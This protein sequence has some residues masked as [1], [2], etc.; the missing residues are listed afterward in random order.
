MQENI[1][2]REESLKQIKETAQ[3]G[4]GITERILNV[5]P[6]GVCITD[7]EGIF[8]YV[9]PRYREIYQYEREELIGQH[10]TIMVPEKLKQRMI[11]LHKQFIE[12]KHEMHGEW[13]VQRKDGKKIS[14]LVS[15]AYL[16]D[17]L[18]GAP[19][20]MTF[21]VDTASLSLST[22]NLDATVEMLNRKLEAQELAFHISSHDMRN[23]IGNISQL[24]DLLRATSLDDK[25]NK[26][27]DIIH[28]LSLRTLDMLKMSADYMKMEKGNYQP[29]ISSFNLL[30]ALSNEI[31]AYSNE[32][33]NR[34]ITFQTCLN[35]EEANFDKQELIVEADKAYMERMLGNLIGNAVEA[36]PDGEQVKLEVDTKDKLK[37]TIHNKG[38][39]PQE[40]RNSFFDKFS[41][42]GKE[43][44]TGLGT[45]IARLVT[46]LHN[47]DISFS[48]S[49][50]EGT[51]LFV[52]LPKEILQDSD[53]K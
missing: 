4:G 36:S 46:E 39:V 43:E 40:M 50:E 53:K 33:E 15:A 48:T 20:K 6:I 45:Y 12:Q 2:T 51:A 47:G 9:N 22:D 7:K 24:A 52:E 41:T 32:S 49:N 16:E 19:Q 26:Y 1:N 29:D 37:V 35:G 5:L 25:Q 11:H 13:E 27:V 3:E 31:G 8:T 14:I 23:N 34:K 21:V 42:A 10:F 18:N 38:E 17:E 30:K 44:G 28:Q